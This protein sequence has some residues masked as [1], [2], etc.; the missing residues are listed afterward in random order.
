MPRTLNGLSNVIFINDELF[1]TTAGDVGTGLIKS[2]ATV[3]DT[4]MI[5]GGTNCNTVYTPA[6]KT[7]TINATGGGGGMTSWDLDDSNGNL[8]T[9]Q[10][11]DKITIAGVTSGYPDDAPI[12]TNGG[13]APNYTC[14]VQLGRSLSLVRNAV[15]N[16]IL[17][18]DGTGQGATNVVTQAPATSLL[19]GAALVFNTT[20]GTVAWEIQ[21]SNDIDV[22]DGAG[23]PFFELDPSADRALMC[24]DTKAFFPVISVD[25]RCVIGTTSGGATS[26]N[27]LSMVCGTTGTNTIS[28][29]DRNQQDSTANTNVDNQF[30]NYGT[31]IDSWGEAANMYDSTIPAAVG[32]TGSTFQVL[33]NKSPSTTFPRMIIGVT[34]IATAFY[35][36][37]GGLPINFNL[38]TTLTIMTWW[39]WNNPTVI[40][41]VSS[42]NTSYYNQRFFNPPPAG[43]VVFTTPTITNAVPGGTID[44]RSMMMRVD[45]S[46]TIQYVANGVVQPN[47]AIMFVCYGGGIQQEQE[48]IINIPPTTTAVGRPCIGSGSC[49]WFIHS[50]SQGAGA[51]I[52]IQY[53]RHNSSTGTLP[54]NILRNQ[55]RWTITNVGY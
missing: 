29:G 3:G 5:V 42:I 36:Q 53:A 39:G 32:G 26:T 16:G 1:F 51:S 13:A 34:P 23:N 31:T 22:I 8:L 25:T 43:G 19:G 48:L 54:V 33:S 44:W 50:D 21:T 28:W 10:N 6:T 2:D 37:S 52:N 18:W 46:L 45:L 47:Y 4:Y 41:P 14:D 49:H 27:K 40:P 15:T 7:L 55:G 35:H 24:D 9:I 11:L 20:L 17:R 12:I 30:G 38:T